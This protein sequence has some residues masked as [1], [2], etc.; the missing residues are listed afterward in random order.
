[1][2]CLYAELEAKCEALKEMEI[3]YKKA[4]E[5]AEKPLRYT[6]RP[7]Y[8]I[9]DSYWSDTELRL[10]SRLPLKLITFFVFN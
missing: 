5:E 2:E 7:N 3:K 9:L 10:Q 6:K 8:T 4:I 1:M